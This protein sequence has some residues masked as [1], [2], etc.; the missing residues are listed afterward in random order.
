V[1]APR[2]RDAPERFLPLPADLAN[3]RE[4]ARTV[5]N[6]IAGLYD[7]ARPGYPPAAVADVVEWSGLRHASAVLEI[8]C[9]TG[10]LT[11]SLAPLGRPMLC[12][13]PGED[14]A[15]LAGANLVAFP[16]VDIV[17]ETFEEWVGEAAAF[18]VVLAATAF[19]WVDPDLSFAKAA[20]LLR[21]GGCLALVTNAHGA[22]GTQ[23]SIA[24]EIQALHRRLA[25]DVHSWR[26]PSV[27]AIE[28]EARRGGDIAAVWRRV[29]RK[30]EPAPPVAGLF[31]APRVGVHPWLATYDVPGFL[32][33]LR[34]QS[35]Y[36]LM[37]QSRRHELLV[38]IGELVDRRLHGVVTKQYVTVVAVA[39]RQDTPRPRRR[40]GVRED[41]AGD[42]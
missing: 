16:N 40:G 28:R 13:E 1:P 21:P 38:R 3:A 27:E 15:R 4:A 12:L 30:F 7:A 37:E 22:G 39:R 5:F 18:D 29:E 8:G 17:C 9:G 25:P 14:L 23:Q 34:S 41:G 33:M 2:R 19:H 26:F 42:G 20:R 24:S 10:Q 36:A 35:T 32:D 31:E 6:R 11:R